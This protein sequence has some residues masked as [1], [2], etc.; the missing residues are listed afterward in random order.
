MNF[1]RAGNSYY[2]MKNSCLNFKELNATFD[3]KT[4]NLFSA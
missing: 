1:G 3:P 2:F 4:L